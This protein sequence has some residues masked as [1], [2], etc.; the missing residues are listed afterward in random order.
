MSTPPE[1]PSPAVTG[2]ILR[3]LLLVYAGTGALA[4]L[5]LVWPPISGYLQALLAALL[6]VVPS[7]VLRGS[8][9]RI[10]DFGVDLGPWR[11]TLAWS[12]LAM[13]VVFPLFTAGHQLVQTTVR[14]GTS[15]WSTAAL[16]RW[17]E[18][19][20]DIPPHPCA[21]DRTR[22][23][24]WATDD[25]LWVVAPPGRAVTVSVP[26]PPAVPGT[27]TGPRDAGPSGPRLAE[28]SDSGLPRAAVSAR[29]SPDRTV[30]TPLGGGLRFSLDG[31][32][33]LDLK[34]AIDGAPI[35]RDRL[36]LGAW[37]RSAD[38]DGEVDGSRSL[39]WIPIFLC[40]HLGLVALPEEWFFRGYLQARLDQRFGT[41]WRLAGA[42]LGWGFI[43][44]SL[45]FAV[46]HPIL[47]P[48]A[49]RLLVFF[50]GL[51]FGWLRARTG[52]IGAAV[53]VHAASNL[54]LAI[55][56]RMVLFPG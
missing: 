30:R 4:V 31:V 36:A 48:G 25:E 24:V 2:E 38:A 13:A 41:P 10:D 26:G 33:T 32:D 51:L 54:L 14:G 19:I 49:H 39:W 16:W 34:L 50:P 12:A 3:S 40:V 45:A 28:C 27:A 47:I 5:A 53:V 21:A 35:P 23:A 18:D 17:D 56:S 42:R 20:R 22:T 15:A 44:A 11:Q 29:V 9:A 43:L 52:N 1:P 37:E 8:T 46:L 7:Y 55:I 6:L